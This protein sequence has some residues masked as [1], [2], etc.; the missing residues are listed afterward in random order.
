MNLNEDDSAEV[1]R[2]VK[3]DKAWNRLSHASLK[4]AN[5][6]VP[7]DFG[8]LRCD[9]YGGML[10]VHTCHVMYTS[11]DDSITRRT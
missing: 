4:G 5:T 1:I 2:V 8:S 7:F 3:Y 6:M 11:S 9:E 10:Y